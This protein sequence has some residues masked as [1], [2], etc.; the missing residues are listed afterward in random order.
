MTRVRFM[1]LLIAVIGLVS[2]GISLLGAEVVKSTSDENFCG[3]CHVMQP[4]VTTFNQDIHGGNNPHGFKAE[5]VD[6]HLPH[7]STAAYLLSKGTQGANDVIKM[8]FTDTDNIN[9]LERRKE[10]EHFVFDSGCL[11]CHQTLLT[12]TQAKNVKSLQMHQ[13]YQAMQKTTD[14]L[15]CVS[16]HVTI[17]HNG[18]LRSELNKTQPEY[19]F[20]QQLPEQK[21]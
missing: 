14:P 6:C 13:H 10:R 5:C 4:M 16:C 11:S 1:V 2:V 3:A 9:W 7:T 8:L 20:L 18:A 21:P 15:T 12:K 19:K 17:G